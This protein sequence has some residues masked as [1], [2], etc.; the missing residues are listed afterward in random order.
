MR[1]L[2]HRLLSV[3]HRFNETPVLAITGTLASFLA[4][5]CILAQPAL[6]E[7]QESD[8]QA[9][10]GHATESPVLSKLPAV[11]SPVKADTTPNVELLRVF[12]DCQVSACDFDHIRREIQ[13]V[14]YVRDREDA[15]VH[16][17]ITRQTASG[18]TAYTIYLLG[19]KQFSGSNDTLQFVERE[20]AT[21]QAERETLTQTLGLGLI[22]YVAKT[23]AGARLRIS[24][25][26]PAAL[27]RPP[28]ADPWNLWVFRVALSGS[29]DGEESAKAYSISGDASARRTS[30]TWKLSFAGV[31]DYRQNSFDLG[32]PERLISISR[33]VRARTQMVGAI[34]DKWST[35]VRA[36]ATTSSYQNEDMTIRVAPALEYSAFPYSESTSRQLRFQY[37]AGPNFFHYEEETIFGKIREMVYSEGLLADLILTQPWGSANFALEGSH[38]LPNFTYHRVTLAGS[39]DIRLFRGLGITLYGSAARIADQLALRRGAATDEEILLRRRELPTSFRY[40]L[41]LGFSYTFGSAFTNIVNPR[42][43]G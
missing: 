33:S 7:Q 35:G 32:E 9:V 27:A 23:P 6:A 22:R 31:V 41:S 37:Y 16:V 20:T 12:L 14:N 30:E 28:A 26:G 39:T 42:F 29:A 11:D 24:Y 34:A 36:S 38:Y 5:G 43:G 19:R 2:G 15:D 17:L 18:G 4:A 3:I 10:L 13:F 8:S 1:L 40:F 25:L 21:R